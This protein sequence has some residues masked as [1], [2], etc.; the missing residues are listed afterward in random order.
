MPGVVGS[1]HHEG[2]KLMTAQTAT[3]IRVR[4]LNRLKTALKSGGLTSTVES[5]G[6]S[7]IVLHVLSLGIDVD[8]RTNPSDGHR[9]SFWLADEPIGPADE[10]ITAAEAIKRRYTAEAT[11]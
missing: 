10:P 11:P 9:W 3:V 7:R 2:Q 6:T 8:C 5:S 1:T 4:A